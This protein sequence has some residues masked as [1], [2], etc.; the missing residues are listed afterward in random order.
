MKVTILAGQSNYAGSSRH[1]VTT[2]D[3][4]GFDGSYRIERPEPTTGSVPVDD[5]A[6]GGDSIK[7]RIAASA[8]RG[9][10]V[11]DLFR[12]LVADDLDRPAL[13]EVAEPGVLPFRELAG[14]E[15]DEIDRLGER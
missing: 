5:A 11:G 13:F 8:E 15:L 9:E 14:A 4:P 3:W 1:G 12:R 7:W 2:Q 6:G 10:P